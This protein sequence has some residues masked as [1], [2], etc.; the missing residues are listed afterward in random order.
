MVKDNRDRERKRYRKKEKGRESPRMM[1]GIRGR[2]EKKDIERQGK[3]E[4]W[5]ER[6]KDGKSKKER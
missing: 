1:E 3:G 6:E 2:E 5:D 4:W